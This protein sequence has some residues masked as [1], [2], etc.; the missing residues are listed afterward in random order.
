MS[1]IRNSNQQQHRKK[2]QQQRWPGMDYF[3][4]HI[5]S[6]HSHSHGI[7][8]GLF[9][10]RNT[11][12]KTIKRQCKE[13]TVEQQKN[14]SAEKN[15]H[16]SLKNKNSKNTVHNTF[17]IGQKFLQSS[18]KMLRDSYSRIAHGPRCHPQ[19]Q[20]QQKKVRWNFFPWEKELFPFPSAFI[21]TPFHS[22]LILIV[23]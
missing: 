12:S 7:S 14:S 1:N 18:F 9:P 16:Q 2:Q 19:Y 6:L 8:T 3:Y 23:Y 13:S 15:G 22:N 11:H 20:Q 10:F 21:P 4:I 5:L 17:K